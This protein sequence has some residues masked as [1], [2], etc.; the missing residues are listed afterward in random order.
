MILR[1]KISII[2][3]FVF[4]SCYGCA[5]NGNDLMDPPDSPSSNDPP[6][7]TLTWVS[8]ARPPGGSLHIARTTSNGKTSQITYL[9]DS[10]Y[11]DYK[12]VISPDSTK[13]AFFRAYNE[14]GNFF[15][16]NSSICVMNADGSDLRELTGHE[17][18]N[19]EPYWTRDGTNCITWSRMIHSSE[20][21][22]GTYV[23]RTGMED[24]PGDEVQISATNW[25][26]GNSSLR[27]G[28]M[29]VSRDGAHFLLN[30][31]PGGN[32]GYEEISYPDSYHYLHKVTISNDETMIAYMKKIDPDGDDYL[33]SQI[34]YANLDASVPAITNEIVFVPK[35]ENKFSWYV[36]ISPD[37]NY[38]IY[39]E[40]GKIMIHDVETNK[41]SQFSTMKEVEYRYPT[42][43]GS[44]K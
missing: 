30:P 19:T 44:V 7:V 28:R 40:D 27:D 4:L 3:V 12:P 6:E 8:S 14:G 36:S 41:N 17:F 24:S 26:W 31:D 2:L 32:P 29:F 43:D 33:G 35:N 38:L 9:T 21:T 34:V 20:G 42:F 39:A 10:P 11:N 5:K 25:E 13:I 18:M 22:F 1:M 16:W 23:Y 37:N 15:L